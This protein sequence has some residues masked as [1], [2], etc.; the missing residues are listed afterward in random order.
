MKTHT[1]ISVDLVTHERAQIAASLKN[2]S[3]GDWFRHCNE[4]GIAHGSIGTD[5]SKIQVIKS[6]TGIRKNIGRILK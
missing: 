2:K 3:L 6:G 5:V 1:N 4:L